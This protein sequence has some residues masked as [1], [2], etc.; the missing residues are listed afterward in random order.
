MINI[1]I[2]RPII[3]VGK[4][5]T[6]KTTKA[7]EILGDNPI[8][9][10]ADEYD[11]EDNFSIPLDKGILI[12]EAGIKPNVDA[13]VRT[14]LQYRGQVVLTSYNQKDV[15]K[16]IYN[17][18]KLKRAGTTN[19]L[20]YT[21]NECMQGSVPPE[22]YDINIFSLIHDFF[23]NSNRDDVLIKLKMN[24]PY[25]EQF[26]SWLVLN[27]HPSKVAY[28]DAKVKRRWSQDYFHELIA[29]AHNGRTNKKVVIPSRRTYSKIP[30]ICRK[31]GLKSHE[32]YLLTQL[33]E[34]A[35]FTQF[36]KSRV[37]NVERRTLQ[38]GDVTR[39]KKPN[40]TIKGL[41]EY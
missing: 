40:I 12:E 10:Y 26:L 28:L 27:M 3:I 11:I 29:Y 8:V 23:K 16:K 20:N 1:A 13:I 32:A 35:D 9:Q 5:G 36:V 25:D 18:C 7:L 31:V 41:G 24:K 15:P 22:D 19:Y 39:Q 17:L 6:G 30:T 14:L 33:L 34:D 2:T 21:V 38:L 37:N 4:P